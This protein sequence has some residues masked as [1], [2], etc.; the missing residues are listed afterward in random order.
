MM[1]LSCGV[2][3]LCVRE[4]AQLKFQ[5]YFGLTL[6]T[7]EVHVSKQLVYRNT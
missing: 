6:P 7:V 1:L 4:I 3:Y 5:Q 2:V